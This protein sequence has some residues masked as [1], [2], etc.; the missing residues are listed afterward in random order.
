MF[1]RVDSM[2]ICLEPNCLEHVKQA[3]DGGRSVCVDLMKMHPKE[4]NM[5][6][7]EYGCINYVW[8]IGLASQEIYLS[9]IPFLDKCLETHIRTYILYEFELTKENVKQAIAAHH[10]SGDIE[11]RK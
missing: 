3:V 5:I 10:T 6:V 11:I 7:G 2:I 4:L 8:I 9:L 1:Y